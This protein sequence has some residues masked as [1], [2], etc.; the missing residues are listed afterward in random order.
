MS[1]VA[2]D[3]LG[4]SDAVGDPAAA[5]QSEE[6]HRGRH[7]H[8]VRRAAEDPERPQE[9][10]THGAGGQLRPQAEGE[11]TDTKSTLIT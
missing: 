9:R 11:V 2:G 4:P 7:P 3:R 5:D 8:D 10:L 6:L 1:Q